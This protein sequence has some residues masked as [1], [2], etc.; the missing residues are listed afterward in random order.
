[1]LIHANFLLRFSFVKEVGQLLFNLRGDDLLE[2]P[3]DRCFVNHQSF[4]QVVHE[5]VVLASVQMVI[6][7]VLEPW[8]SLG[9]V[10]A[11]RGSSVYSEC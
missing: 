3:F 8:L 10:A 9:A 11:C 2:F 4:L 1:M 6:E 5:L 7:L